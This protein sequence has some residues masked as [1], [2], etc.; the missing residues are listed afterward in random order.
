VRGG[1]LNLHNFRRDEWT[2]AVRAAGLEHRK[3][4]ALRHSYAAWMIAAGVGLFACRG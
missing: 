4:Y 1:H 3:P 2:P